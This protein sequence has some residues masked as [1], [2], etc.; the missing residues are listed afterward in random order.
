M[1]SSIEPL[2]LEE[3]IDAVAEIIDVLQE[4]AP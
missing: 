2:P 4:Y 3:Q 1:T